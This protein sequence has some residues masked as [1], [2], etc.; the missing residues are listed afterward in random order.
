MIL[1]ERIQSEC[2]EAIY[3]FQIMTRKPHVISNSY[4]KEH[5]LWKEKP[6]KIT[7]A[8]IP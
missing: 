8:Q 2:F 4:W 5:A 1:K 7:N 6:C 3:N